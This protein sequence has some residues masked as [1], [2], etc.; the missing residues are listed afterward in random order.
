[1][2]DPSAVT[3]STENRRIRVLEDAVALLNF[4]MRELRARVSNL[5]NANLLIRQA[6][7]QGSGGTGITAALFIVTTTI[8][9]MTSPP[10][11]GVGAGT[12]QSVISGAYNATGTTGVP[13]QSFYS[14]PIT[15]GAAVLVLAIQMSDL[16]WLVDGVAC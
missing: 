7:S 3:E 14:T 8:T 2:S 4:Q 13:L 1:M 5:E 9:A 16:S 11:F 10:T 15:A 12:L 6:S